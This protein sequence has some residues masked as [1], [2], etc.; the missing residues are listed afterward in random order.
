[1]WETAYLCNNIIIK[2]NFLFN[3][4]SFY[5]WF[6]LFLDQTLWCFDLELGAKIMFWSMFGEGVCG[7]WIDPTDN[8][9]L[10][11]TILFSFIIGNL[12]RFIFMRPSKMISVVLVTYWKYLGSF[13][14]VFLFCFHLISFIFYYLYMGKVG[15][16]LAQSHILT[17]YS[18]FSTQ[19][20][21][22]SYSWQN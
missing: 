5:G 22:M 8:L 21:K 11:D 6:E 12:S 3:T 19:A 9:S 13:R 4:L 14:P 18:T 10:A 2:C 16:L 1:M 15:I 17:T 20:S 7:L